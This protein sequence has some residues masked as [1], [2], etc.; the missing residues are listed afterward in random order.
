MIANY[1][2]SACVD[3]IPVIAFINFIAASYLKIKNDK[4]IHYTRSVMS[5]TNLI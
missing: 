4:N 1:L 3:N 5:K 2:E